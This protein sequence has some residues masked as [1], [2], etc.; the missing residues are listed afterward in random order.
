M[1]DFFFFS[2]LYDPYLEEDTSTED[3]NF[4]EASI[5]DLHDSEIN[6]QPKT[7]SILKNLIASFLSVTGN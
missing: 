1:M 4:E 3:I 6:M 7:V 2:T 5:E